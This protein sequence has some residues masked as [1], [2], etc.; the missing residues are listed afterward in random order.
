MTEFAILTT[1]SLGRPVHGTAAGAGRFAAWFAGSKVVDKSGRPLVVYHGTC[2]DIT[3]FDFEYVRSNDELG[4]F[5][6]VDHHVAADYAEGPGGNVMPLYLAIRT[7]YEMDNDERM[8][9]QVFGE[10]YHEGGTTGFVDDLK[11]SGYDG[12][13]VPGDPSGQTIEEQADQ[14][15]PFYPEQIKSAIGNDWTFSPSDH[16][17]AGKDHHAFPEPTRLARLALALKAA[18]HSN[19]NAPALKIDSRRAPSAF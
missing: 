4:I 8:M 2:A 9:I 3:A 6:S 16:A 18:R 12:I 11:S 14:W 17:I 5:T 10:E 1:N 7:P 15:I 19:P 13:F